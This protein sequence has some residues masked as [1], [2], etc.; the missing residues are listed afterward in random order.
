[1]EQD[2]I[3]IKEI[4]NEVDKNKRPYL[5]VVD[6][7][8]NRW[9]LFGELAKINFDAKKAYLF[10]YEV[11]GEYKQVRSVELLSNVF[12]VQALKEL[13]SKSEI[14]KDLFMSVSYAKDMVVGGVLEPQSMMQKAKE[15]YDFINIESDKIMEA[16]Q[17]TNTP[18]KKEPNPQVSNET[19]N[20][21]FKQE[22]NQH[23]NGLKVDSQNP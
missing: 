18:I 10:K 5:S 8:N 22:V 17:T 19:V 20:K 14:K 6:G 4:K 12:K 7:Y 9:Y 11:N 3:V 1:M 21:M 2:A 13:A 16:L 15:I 23:L